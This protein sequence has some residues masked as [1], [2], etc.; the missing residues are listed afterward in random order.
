MRQRYVRMRKCVSE[1]CALWYNPA[2]HPDCPECK[3]R[4]EMEKSE[5]ENFNMEEIQS[6]AATS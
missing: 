2:E 5:S 4:K 3:K 1:G 6:E